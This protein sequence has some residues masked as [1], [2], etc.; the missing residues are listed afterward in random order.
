[1]DLG[2]G[3]SLSYSLEKASNDPAEI[4]A[5]HAEAARLQA[6]QDQQVARYQEKPV[7]V[8]EA[9]LEYQRKEREEMARFNSE[10]A[11]DAARRALVQPEGEVDEDLPV[12]KP[13]A[14]KVLSKRWD[15]YVGQSAGNNWSAGRT[16]PAFQAMFKEF[17]DWWG[18]DQDIRFITRKVVN[19]FIVHLQRDRVIQSG[20]RKGQAGSACAPWTTT[21]RC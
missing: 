14:E 12:F 7:P 20:A 8:H 4:A 13:S 1:M 9:M 21:R 11:A 17:Q 18:P 6:K 15:E 10:L 2:G 3:R 16:T 19:R 5:F